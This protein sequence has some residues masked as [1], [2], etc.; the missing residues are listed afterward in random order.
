MPKLAAL[1]TC[2]ENGLAINLRTSPRLAKKQ[3]AN[4][5]AVI[6]DTKMQT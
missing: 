3:A 5:A 1:A 6:K 2:L 4:P